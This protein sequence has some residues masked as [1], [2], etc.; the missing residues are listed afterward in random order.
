LWGTVITASLM[1]STATFTPGGTL[2]LR[3]VAHRPVAG[4]SGLSAHLGRHAGWAGKPRNVLHSGAGSRAYGGAGKQPTWAWPHC[5]PTDSRSSWLAGNRWFSHAAPT[6]L[7]AAGLAA[8]AK[9]RRIR[10]SSEIGQ[11]D[12][13]AASHD[14]HPAP[15]RTGD[16]WRHQPRRHAGRSGGLQ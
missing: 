2:P 14:H 8:L 11:G 7:F 3:P 1:F 5:S 9:P 10:F 4:A 16:G 12:R 15:G 13:R 6:L